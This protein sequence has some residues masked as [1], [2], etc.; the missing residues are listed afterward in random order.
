MQWIVG[1]GIAETH[2]LNV[3]ALGNFGGHFE[4]AVRLFVLN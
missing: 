3:F 4:L 2:C 1:I